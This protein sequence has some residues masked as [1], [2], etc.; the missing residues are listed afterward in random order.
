MTLPNRIE[1][2]N[3]HMKNLYEQQKDLA[4][5]ISFVAKKVDG[6]REKL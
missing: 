6:Y 2:L 5:T 4:E 1:I 3:N